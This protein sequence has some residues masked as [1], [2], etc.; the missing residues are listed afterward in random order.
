MIRWDSRGLFKSCYSKF[1]LVRLN[2]IMRTSSEIAK[3]C[4]IER[5]FTSLF[6]GRVSDRYESFLLSGIVSVRHMNVF[7]AVDR[8]FTDYSALMDQL[9]NNSIIFCHKLYF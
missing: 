6:G 5:Y 8:S 4:R 3:I 9:L 1:R 2:K 7:S